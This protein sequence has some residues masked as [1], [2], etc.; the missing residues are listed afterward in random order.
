MTQSKRAPRSI[1]QRQAAIMAGGGLLLLLALLTWNSPAS[2]AGGYWASVAMVSGLLLG[3]GALS[4]WLLWSPLPADVPVKARSN[5]ALRQIAA[6]AIAAG[7]LV[8]LGGGLWD[9]AWRQMYGAAAQ[10]SLLSWQ[11]NLLRYGSAGLIAVTALSITFAAARGPGRLRARWRQDTLLAMLGLFSL[12]PL[13]I[14]AAMLIWHRVVAADSL[15]GGGST[16]VL[17]VSMAAV[18]LAA[19][20]VQ[21]SVLPQPTEW[22]I[23]RLGLGELNTIILLAVA[24]AL[25][26]LAGAGGW[27]DEAGR[28]ARPDWF[29]PAAILG[30]AL[31]S[32][33]IGLHVLR[34][35]GTGVLI[36]AAALLFRATTNFL[37]QQFFGMTEVGAAAHF[38]ALIPAA[39]MDVVYVY[40]APEANQMRTSWLAIGVG[41]AALLVSGLAL[42]PRLVDYPPVDASTLPSM[43]LAGIGVGIFCG[44]CGAHVG[45]ALTH[46]HR[47][48][49][50]AEG[51]RLRLAAIGAGTYSVLLIAAFFFM[52]SASLPQ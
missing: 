1:T 45:Q 32:G 51:T 36:F 4:W 19:V 11:P 50:L 41:S 43:I 28:A 33:Q 44:W 14:S 27:E 46:V 29:Y 30:V 6:Y 22:T 38:L 35:P 40:R 21:N 48:P 25:L 16:L 37:F 34:R 42:I 10:R 24:A 2:H 39:A 3:L 31:F 9:E 18:M 20:A 26:L 5:P 7:G 13:L 23:R 49:P 52:Q 47:L 17:D 8:F 15:A 12:D